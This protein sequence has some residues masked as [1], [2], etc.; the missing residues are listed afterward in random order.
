[1]E[2]YLMSVNQ[3]QGH[4]FQVVLPDRTLASEE[5]FYK[6]FLYGVEWTKD[7]E[8]SLRRVNRKKPFNTFQVFDLYLSK[9]VKPKHRERLVKYVYTS[10]YQV[11]LSVYNIQDPKLNDT[12]TAAVRNFL[13]LITKLNEANR[14][15]DDTPIVYKG[16][17][18]LIKNLNELVDAIKNQNNA[19]FGIKSE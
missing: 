10:I 1:M 14:K 3:Y 17:D 2:H 13:L 9:N 6:G 12:F 19:Y 16:Y 11:G 8:F 7:L 15:N 4:L 18:L 5:F